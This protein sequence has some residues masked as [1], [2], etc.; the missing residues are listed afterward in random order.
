MTSDADAEMLAMLIDSLIQAG[1]REF[2]VEIGHIDFFNGLMEEAGLSSEDRREL[3][4]L[5]ESKNYFGVEEM[6][7]SRDMPEN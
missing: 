5:I 4:A 7:S 2:Q 1:L 3:R 6:L